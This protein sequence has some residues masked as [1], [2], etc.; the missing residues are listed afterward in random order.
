MMKRTA[1]AF[2]TTCDGVQWPG[3][4]E[5]AI[6]DIVITYDIWYVLAT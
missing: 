6:E 4:T 2:W 1:W 3:P 5:V